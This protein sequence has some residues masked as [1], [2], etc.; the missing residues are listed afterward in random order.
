MA[1]KK[2]VTMDE[3][4]VKEDNDLVRDVSSNAIINTNNVAYEAR[5]AQIEKT[6]LDAQQSEDIINLKKDVEEIKKLLKK[7]ASK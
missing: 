2:K 6:K 1:R 5:L 4:I 3:L 7:I